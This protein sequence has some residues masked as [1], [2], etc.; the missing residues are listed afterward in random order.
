[1]VAADLRDQARRAY[2]ALEQG[3]AGCGVKRS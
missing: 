1:V 3:L 2:E